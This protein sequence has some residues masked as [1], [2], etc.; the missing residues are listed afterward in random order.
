MLT[1]LLPAV[2]TF[3]HT[4]EDHEHF[5]TCKLAGEIHVHESQL[6]CD[7]G[8][9]QMVKLGTYAFAKAYSIPTPSIS[10]TVSE[11]LVTTYT[12]FVAH[13]ESRGPP[14]C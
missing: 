12:Q 14:A 3:I 5:D 11:F 4:T 10:T 8:D 6:D 7:L 13:S 9:L 2:V 1:F